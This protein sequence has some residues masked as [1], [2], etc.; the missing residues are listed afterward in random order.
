MRVLSATA[1]AT[2]VARN[3]RMSAC[4]SCACAEVATLPVPMAQ[5]GSYAITTFLGEPQRARPGRPRRVYSLPVRLREELDGGR[6]LRLADRGGLVRL[7][8]R[9]G[10]ADA[11]DDGEPVVERD[12]G[13]FRDEL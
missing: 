6:E 11:E 12:A 7:A 5:T 9:E 4:A 3:A 1:G 2:S 10:L 13:L 8:L